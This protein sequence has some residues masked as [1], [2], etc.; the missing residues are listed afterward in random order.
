MSPARRR[1]LVVPAAGAPEARTGAAV[2]VPAAGPACTP[3][4]PSE[5]PHPHGAR[6]SLG[7]SPG[8]PSGRGGW[9]WGRPVEQVLPASPRLLGSHYLQ[10][11]QAA[12]GARQSPPLPTP[13][14]SS[15]WAEGTLESAQPWELGDV[16]GGECAVSGSTSQRHSHRGTCVH[17]PRDE[18]PTHIVRGNMESHSH[19]S[20]VCGLG[21]VSVRQ[22]PR[23][24]APAQ[25]VMERPVLEEER[26]LIQSGILWWRAETGAHTGFWS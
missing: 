11:V 7:D 17:I 20:D 3:L 8:K 24:C 26:T 13:T 18:G 9:G 6:E 23:L 1:H 25:T 21:S 14:G 10:A 22:V 5:R 15:V 4:C 16:D 19:S 12:P 2:T